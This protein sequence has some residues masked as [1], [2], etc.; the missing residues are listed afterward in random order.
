MIALGPGDLWYRIAARGHEVIDFRGPRPGSTLMRSIRRHARNGPWVESTRRWAGAGHPLDPA[1]ITAVAFAP[2]RHRGVLVGLLVAGTDVIGPA[3]L[4]RRLASIGELADVASA[5][6]GPRFA[7]QAHAADV[8]GAIERLIREAAFRPVYQPIVRLRDGAILG[9]EALTRFA[10]G[11]RPDVRFAEAA[12][13]GFGLDLELATL[14]AALDGATTL[15]NDALLSVNVSPAL[16]NQ[17]L[18]IEDLLGRAGQG[19]NI[20]LE[21]TEHEPVDDYEALRDAISHMATKVRWAIDDAGAGYASLRHILELRPHF[22][23]LDRA[24]IVNVALDPA[25]QALIAGLLHFSQALGTTLV[26]EGIETSAERLALEDLGLT[27]GQGYLFGR[28]ES[29][30]RWR[31]TA[32]RRRA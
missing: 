31:S 27:A 24:L 23:K 30:D 28:P 3:G 21:I 10:D 26:A 14:G 19:R 22:V 18:H 17:G 16:I 4:E 5:M 29:A 1:G 2:V 11:S 12:A 7:E 13:V 9:Y 32:N 6:L 15:P 20:V 25:R 8:R